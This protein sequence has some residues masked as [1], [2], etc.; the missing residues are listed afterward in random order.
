MHILR[1]GCSRWRGLCDKGPKASW[2]GREE[3]LAVQWEVTGRLAG[4]T[5]FISA[6]R[7]T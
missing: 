3:V 5:S 2:P 4:A 1:G 6:R 7:Q